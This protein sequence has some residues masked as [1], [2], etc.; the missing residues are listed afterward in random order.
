MPYVVE[1]SVAGR[2]W[3]LSHPRGNHSGEFR[4]LKSAERF[5]RRRSRQTGDVY[6][7]L[8]ITKPVVVSGFDRGRNTAE[9]LR[10]E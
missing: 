6:R 4:T 3:Y 2:V 10:E 8:S 5:A 9:C 7:V 1:L